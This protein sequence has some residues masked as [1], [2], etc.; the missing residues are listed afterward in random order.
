MG[1]IDEYSEEEGLRGFPSPQGFAKFKQ[2][3]CKHHSCILCIEG[4]D[5]R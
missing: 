3:F 1:N 2:V 5:T 4:V